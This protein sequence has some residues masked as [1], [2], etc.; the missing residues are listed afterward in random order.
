MVTGGVPKRPCCP[1]SN[2]RMNRAGIRRKLVQ[3]QELGWIHF[4]HLVDVALGEA[5]LPQAIEEKLQAIGMK[6]VAGLSHV[7]GENAMLYA[8]GAYCFGVVGKVE[9][10]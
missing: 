10:F 3:T 1:G 6:R 8:D 4:G 2:R 7:G 5:L 9:L